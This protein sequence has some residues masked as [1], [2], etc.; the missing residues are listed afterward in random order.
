[1]KWIVIDDKVATWV[2]TNGTRR[3]FTLFYQPQKLY[4]AFRFQL[5]TT[6]P[7]TEIQ[8]FGRLEFY[9]V[10]D[11]EL[12]SNE[13]VSAMEMSGVTPE[14]ANMF[15]EE[16]TIGMDSVTANPAT[17]S[18]ETSNVKTTPSVTTE[19]SREALETTF[20]PIATTT[21]I[22]P[23][24]SDAIPLYSGIPTTSTSIIAQLSTQ[25]ESTIEPTSVS[26]SISADDQSLSQNLVITSKVSSSVPF[27][28]TSSRSILSSTRASSSSSQSTT[29]TSAKRVE[30]STVVKLS[31]SQ[32]TNSAKRVESSTVVKLSSSQSTNSAK[33]VESSTVTKLSSTAS[34]T[35]LAVAQIRASSRMF[36]SSVPSIPVVAPFYHSTLLPRTTSLQRQETEPK[37]TVPTPIVVSKDSSIVLVNPASLN[38]DF[39]AQVKSSA[40]FLMPAPTVVKASSA[41]GD[42]KSK[43]VDESSFGLI[44][45]LAGGVGMFLY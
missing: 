33:R 7:V 40:S 22:L 1:M 39:V 38:I 35:T 34:T 10:V 15:I 31:S 17:S 25:N 44:V 14:S 9:N 26:S 18:T 24:S 45:G 21:S 30:S 42:T 43:K 32:S 29:T 13:V 2:W 20:D 41:Q 19:T 28:I 36:I 3:T 8:L 11:T 6:S 16:S 4:D 12:M 37:S 23:E 27:S 5:N